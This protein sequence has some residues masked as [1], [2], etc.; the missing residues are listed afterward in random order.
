M[1]KDQL[2]DAPIESKYHKFMNDL[3]GSLDR[4]FN[5]DAKRGERKTGFVL[6]VFDFGDGAGRCN[7]ISN[8]DR[9]DVTTLLREQLRR[10]EGQAEPPTGHA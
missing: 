10:F 1:K 2:G 5:G 8:A 9:A 7:Y 6:M 3:A 4:L